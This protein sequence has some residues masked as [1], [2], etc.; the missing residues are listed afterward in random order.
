MKK[1]ILL[2]LVSFLAFSMNARAQ[3]KPFQLGFRLGPSIGW[4]SPD[5]KGYD[6]DGAKIG[7]NWGFVSEISL[8]QNYKFVTGFSFHYLNG[9]MKQPFESVIA[10]DTLIG[11]ASRNI[12][13]QYLEIPLLMKMRTNPIGD[14][15]FYGQIGFVTGIKLK[16]KSNDIFIADGK[17]QENDE[18]LSDDYTLFRESML[19]GFGIEY[20]I[21]ES[22][23]ITAGINFNKGLTDMMKGDNM[24]NG[25]SQSATASDFELQIGIIF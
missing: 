22:T 21:D 7:F 19:V 16:A 10:A 23:F 18:N 2:C 3:V 11:V 15:R 9:K 13:L 12:K 17:T 25:E 6:S 14:F 20:P 5:T 24:V 8:T 4:I 1:I